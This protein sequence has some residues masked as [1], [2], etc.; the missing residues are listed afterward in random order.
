MTRSAT[1]DGV[2]HSAELDSHTSFSRIPVVDIAALVDPAS[3]LEARRAVGSEL[4]QACRDVGFFYVVGH[5]CPPAVSDGVRAAARE[6]FARPTA[7]KDLVKIRRGTE[8][9]GYQ[10]LGSN[11]TRHDGG[12]TRDWHEAEAYTRS[13]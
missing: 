11:V 10:G 3:T 5:G 4:N 12:F 6:W 2:T 8:G 13:H 1:D 9:R 7:E